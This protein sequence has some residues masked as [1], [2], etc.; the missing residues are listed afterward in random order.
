MVK[1][2]KQQNEFQLIYQANKTLFFA[3]QIK[4]YNTNLAVRMIYAKLTNLLRLISI[5]FLNS[6]I[7]NLVKRN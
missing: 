1:P 5:L 6:K 3:S 4:R 7:A 2:E